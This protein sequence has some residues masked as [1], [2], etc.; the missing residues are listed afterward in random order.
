MA[1]VG[2]P[3]RQIAEV[4]GVSRSL[5]AKDLDAALLELVRPAGDQVRALAI[6]RAEWIWR[7]AT[8]VVLA[9]AGTPASIP[10][11]TTASRA[12]NTLVRLQGVEAAIELKVRI[13][14]AIDAEIRLPG[15]RACC[16]RRTGDSCPAAPRHGGATKR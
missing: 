3:Q 7:Q 11:L 2:V 8:K 6:A 15:R 5:V 1:A 10:A 14:D 16:P 13:E 9:T 12:L 4:L